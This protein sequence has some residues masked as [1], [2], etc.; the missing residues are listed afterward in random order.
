MLQLVKTPA[1]TLHYRPASRTRTLRFALRTSSSACILRRRR[2]RISRQSNAQHIGNLRLSLPSLDSKRTLIECLNGGKPRFAWD[3]LCLPTILASEL[4]K[5][6]AP[7][8]QRVCH[9][10]A[11]VCVG[12]SLLACP[13]RIHATAVQASG[14]WAAAAPEVNPFRDPI[15]SR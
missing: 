11:T 2:A 8:F 4:A 3:I 5:V 9:N 15:S 13:A 6:F 14:R 12:I 10:G 7:R 1:Q